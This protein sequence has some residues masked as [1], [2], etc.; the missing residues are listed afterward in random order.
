MARCLGFLS[1]TRETKVTPYHYDVFHFGTL[2]APGI[3]RMRVIKPATLTVTSIGREYKGSSGEHIGHDKEDKTALH[4][5]DPNEVEVFSVIPDPIIP[6]YSGTFVLDIII[7]E[8]S[9]AATDVK[10]LFASSSSVDWV[11]SSTRYNVL[12]VYFALSCVVI[13]FSRSSIP[14]KLHLNAIIVC[15]RAPNQLTIDSIALFSLPKTL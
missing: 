10:V 13:P 4:S 11:L 7:D 15:Q 5:C 8:G 9:A 12:H 6:P 3:N 14:R 1:P 2:K